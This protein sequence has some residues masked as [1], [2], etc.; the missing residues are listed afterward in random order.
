GFNRFAIFAL[1]LGIVPNIP[2]FLL[3]VKLVSSTAFPGWISHLYNYAWFV[4]F[5]VS[6]FVYWLFMKKMAARTTAT[7]R[8]VREEV[9]VD[10]PR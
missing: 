5:L 7:V 1:L 10:L 6:G 8:G 3:Q 2:G 9:I 4:G